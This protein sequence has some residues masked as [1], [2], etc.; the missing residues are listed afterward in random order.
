MSAKARDEHNRWR[1]K[2]VAFRMSPEESEALDR[3]I[4]LSGLTKQ[5]Y[6]TRKL[7]NKD[8]IVRGNPRVFKALK[9][10]LEGI[11][12]ELQRL[13]QMPSASEEFLE[14]VRV[15]SRFLA[16]MNKEDKS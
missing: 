4:A 10:T 13:G 12:A 5:E 14:T 9:G 2:T 6:I 16:E 8:V 7:V 15:V 11:Y 1:N 3:M